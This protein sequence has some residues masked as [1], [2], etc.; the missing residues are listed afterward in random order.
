MKPHTV[1]LGEMTNPEVEAF[2]KTHHTVIVPTGATEQHG[3][4]GPLLTDVIIP[5]EVA[6]RVAPRIGAV[7][8]PPI[9]YALSYPHVG[10]PGLVHIRIPT[11]MALIAD[12]CASFAA[13]GF[14]RIIFLNGHYDNTYAIAYACADAAERMPKD[15]KAFPINHWDGLTAGEAAEFFSLETGLHAN[16]AETSAVLAIDADLVDLEH[17]NAEFPPFPEFTVNTGPVH[18][19]FFF[20]SPGSVHRATKSGTWGD[21]R[22][23][24]REFGERY[25]EAAVGSTLRV[26]ENIENMFVAMPPR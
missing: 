17:A 19:A 11:F 23:S 16:A 14:K 8:A 4:H 15:V 26:L 22:A 18:T 13:S 12:L 10:F 3:P 9:N 20:T 24:T 25:L 7:V 2:L 6:R 21:A 5:Q 1:F